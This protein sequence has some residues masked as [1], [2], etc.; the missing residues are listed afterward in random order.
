MSTST[1]A[2]LTQ[3]AETKFGKVIDVQNNIFLIQR[4]KGLSCAPLDRYMTIEGG[5]IDGNP[6]FHNGDYDM[7]LADA[8]KNF[9][10][11][12]KLTDQLD[13]IKAREQALVTKTK[14]ATL[15][16][17]L[18]FFDTYLND[19]ITDGAALSDL[20]TADNLD[21]VKAAFLNSQNA[22]VI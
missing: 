14:D 9:A 1:I 19:E 16:A 13:Q 12:A 21:I 5:I 3:A 20:V 15:N 11:R 8:A 7:S 4:A 18:D 22:E 10:M 17:F 6:Q 2:T